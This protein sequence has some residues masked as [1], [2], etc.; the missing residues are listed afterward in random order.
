MLSKAMNKISHENKR[1]RRQIRRNPE[2]YLYNHA[3]RRARDAGLPFEIVPSDILIPLR[4]PVFG[5]RIKVFH[6]DRNKCVSLDR[7]IPSLG[8]VPGNVVVISFKANRLKSNATLEEIL[9]LA[10]WLK[11][12]I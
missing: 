5:F 6:K 10:S 4:C 7:I 1:Q 8:Y 2:K 12:I 3:K 9:A 11:R